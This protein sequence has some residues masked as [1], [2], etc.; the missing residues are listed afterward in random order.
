MQLRWSHAVVYV[1]DLPNMLD[2]YTNV[3]GFQ[4]IDR[5]PVDEFYLAHSK[6]LN[7]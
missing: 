7:S 6:R 4:I 5:G 3:L 1:R 2:F